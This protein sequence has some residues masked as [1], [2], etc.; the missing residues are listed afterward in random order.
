[1]SIAL[2]RL[3]KFDHLLISNLLHNLSPTSSNTPWNVARWRRMT[4]ILTAGP[5]AS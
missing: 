5:F 2:R 4:N 1:L 3:V